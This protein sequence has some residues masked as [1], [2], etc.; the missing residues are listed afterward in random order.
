MSGAR[1]RRVDPPTV[2]AILMLVPAIVAA[3]LVVAL[4]AGRARQ[5]DDPLFDGPPPRSMA[6]A[7]LDGDV[8]SAFAFVQAGRDPN[9]PIDATLADSSSGRGRRVRITPLALAV[10][11][12]DANN[13]RMLLST[14]VDMRRPENQLALCVARERHDAELV[15]LLM[16]AVPGDPTCPARALD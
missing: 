7:I 2:A 3:L 4:E 13:V 12:G 8:E 15:T 16:R 10:A 6:R 11:A 9:L 5:P 14:G 1:H